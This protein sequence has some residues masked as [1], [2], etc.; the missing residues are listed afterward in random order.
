VAKLSR[1]LQPIGDISTYCERRNARDEADKEGLV[2]QFAQLIEAVR[3]NEKVKIGTMVDMIQ[4]VSPSGYDPQPA[5]QNIL[6][7]KYNSEVT[8]CP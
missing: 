1:V 4:R 6:S 3:H 8:P 2:R 5:I 7:G